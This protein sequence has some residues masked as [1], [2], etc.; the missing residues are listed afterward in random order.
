MADDEIE[1]GLHEDVFT[2]KRWL[3]EICRYLLL[4]ARIVLKKV[5]GKVVRERL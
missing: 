2:G 3:A 4:Q 5:G 1:R